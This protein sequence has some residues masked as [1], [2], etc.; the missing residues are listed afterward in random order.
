MNQSHEF[1]NHAVLLLTTRGVSRLKESSRSITFNKKNLTDINRVLG[2][3][4]VCGKIFESLIMYTVN[5]TNA[6][7]LYAINMFKP[8]IPVQENFNMVK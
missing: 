3:K 8:T 1:M 5:K 2:S 7:A 6:S 4:Y